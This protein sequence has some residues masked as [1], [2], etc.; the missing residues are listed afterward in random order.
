[1]R[2]PRQGK[3]CLKETNHNNCRTQTVEIFDAMANQSLE[4][5]FQEPSLFKVARGVGRGVE[6][7]ES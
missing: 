2:S 4:R 7:E 3:P 1:M 5:P 6:L